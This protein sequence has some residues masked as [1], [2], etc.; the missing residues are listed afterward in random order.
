MLL[1]HLMKTLFTLVVL[2]SVLTAAAATDEAVR[3]LKAFP[4]AEPGMKRMGD[5][6]HQVAGEH[7]AARWIDRHGRRQDLLPGPGVPAG[8]IPPRFRLNSPTRL[9]ML[10]PP[11]KSKFL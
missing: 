3:N 8:S 2:A 11:E 10:S 7:R 9:G 5:V 1:N 6:Q 4:P